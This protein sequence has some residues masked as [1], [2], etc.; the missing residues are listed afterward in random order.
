[1]NKRIKTTMA[2]ALIAL[3]SSAG[4]QTI[5]AQ[6]ELEYAENLFAIVWFER[7]PA[8]KTPEHAF[9]LLHWNTTAYRNGFGATPIHARTAKVFN[10]DKEHFGTIY[11]GTLALAKR[12]IGNSKD[13]SIVFYLQMNLLTTTFYPERALKVEVFLNRRTAI[14]TH[15]ETGFRRM[16]PVQRY[17]TKH[18]TDST[19]EKEPRT[20]INFGPIK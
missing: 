4:M 12:E 6:G 1:M 19:H 9:Q 14:I 11:N 5:Q 8:D 17:A 18:E 2:I 7:K 10:T 3:A 15:E 16:V 13:Y 20:A